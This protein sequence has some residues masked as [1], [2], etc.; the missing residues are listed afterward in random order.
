MEKKF[1]IVS[2]Y[3]KK[4]CYFQ[5]TFVILSLAEAYYLI[6]VPKKAHYKVSLHAQNDYFAF[7]VHFFQSMK[8][9]E[10]A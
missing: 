4:I 1:I 7:I 2:L 6:R 9:F 10:T 8:M 3:R 5:K